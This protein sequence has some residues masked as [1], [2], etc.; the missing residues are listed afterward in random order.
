LSEWQ[1]AWIVFSYSEQ[2][3]LG[4]IVEWEFKAVL[5]RKA[6]RTTQKIQYDWN[7]IFTCPA[8]VVISNIS[9]ENEI[10]SR[11]CKCKEDKRLLQFLALALL[12]SVFN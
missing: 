4:R 11:S 10:R 1:E 8:Q 12:A 3:S 2:C 9:K 6:D 7:W 5:R